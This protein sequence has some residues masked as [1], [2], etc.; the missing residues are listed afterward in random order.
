MLICLDGI[1]SVNCINRAG[2]KDGWSVTHRS[3]KITYSNKDEIT[4]DYGE[5]SSFNSDRNAFMKTRDGD[6]DQIVEA[7]TRSPI[8]PVIE[9]TIELK[10]PYKPFGAYVNRRLR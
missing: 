7:M 3:I 10:Q 8:V 1:L 2:S 4:I 6:F 9:N 5:D